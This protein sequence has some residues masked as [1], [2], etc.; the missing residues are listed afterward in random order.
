MPIF[1]PFT[2]TA[3]AAMDSTLAI[4]QS[5]NRPHKGIWILETIEMLLLH[6]IFTI[7]FFLHIK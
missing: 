3:G 1:I 4:L 7:F 5:T 2:A 6:F